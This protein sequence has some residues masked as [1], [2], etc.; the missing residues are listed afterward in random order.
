[1]CNGRGGGLAEQCIV[2]HAAA[3][4]CQ[5]CFFPCPAPFL[6][7][8]FFFYISIYINPMSAKVACSILYASLVHKGCFC[9]FWTK[10]RK[11]KKMQFLINVPGS[12]FTSRSCGDQGSCV[13]CS[14][15]YIVGFSEL[16]N[17]SVGLGK[18]STFP[19]EIYYQSI[20][21]TCVNSFFKKKMKKIYTKKKR[22]YGFSI[23][24]YSF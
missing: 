11:K 4:W 1:M 22:S 5:L 14:G 8:F 7:V 9:F 19:P 3:G 23:T 6:K 10:E 13:L 18:R 21:R 12:C 24:M 20:K 15:V 16:W 2:G 17:C